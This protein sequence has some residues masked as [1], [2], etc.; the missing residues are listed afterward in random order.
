MESG[1]IRGPPT[2]MGTSR[3]GA[4]ETPKRL[5]VLVVSQ[6]PL[7]RTAVFESFFWNPGGIRARR[8]NPGSGGFREPRNRREPI[9]ASLLARARSSIGTAPCELQLARD[10]IRGCF[11][12][13]LQGQFSPHALRPP[14][15]STTLWGRR[16][17]HFGHRL[18]DPANR[19]S[20]CSAHD[21]TECRARPFVGQPCS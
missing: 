5:A 1:G 14:T 12:Y 19:P 2:D 10:S 8:R 21:P 6:Y 15:P 11:A 13:T 9:R 7:L 17:L 3:P 20:R 4:Q 18:D 16:K